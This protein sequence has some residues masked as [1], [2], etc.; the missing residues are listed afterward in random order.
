E[1]VEVALILHQRS[2]RQVIEV[3]DPARREVLVHRLHQGEILAQRDWHAGL[4]ELGEER[5]KH[6][7][8][9]RP[10]ALRVKVPASLQGRLPPYSAAIAGTSSA[11]PAA[12]RAW[13]MNWRALTSHDRLSANCRQASR[14]TCSA[15]RHAARRSSSITPTGA[16]PITSREPVT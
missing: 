15:F 16:L 3:L 10:N 11:I 8:T 14:G 1:L 9:F 6:T 2:A 5:D 7:R 12:R 4:L 13:P